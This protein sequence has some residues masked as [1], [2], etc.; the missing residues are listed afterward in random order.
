MKKTVLILCL[1]LVSCGL[2]AQDRSIN[3]ETSDFQTALAKAKQA[4]R[5]LFIDCYTSWCGPCKMLAK[6]VFTNNA[7]AD[8]FNANFVSMKV[9]CE[10]GEGPQIAGQFGV[11]SYPTLLF[12]DGDGNLVYKTTGASAPDRFLERVKEG[13]NPENLLSVKEKKYAEGVRDRALM[14][15]LIA[16]YKDRRDNKKAV[17][18]S[19]ELL[20]ALN[21]KELLN[22]EMWDV[23]QYYFVSGYGSKWWN[24]IIEHSDE[25]VGI[26]G[27]EAVANKIGETLHPYLFGFACG[28]DRAK[29]KADFEN[30]KT[31]VDRFQPKQKETLYAFIELGKSASSDNFNGYFKTVMRV[32]PKMDAGEHYRFWFN[33][34][35]NLEPNLSAKQ[36]KQLVQL[37]KSDMEK[38]NEYMQKAYKELL[39]KM[40]E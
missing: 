3:F 35:N 40:G 7:V 15:D 29:N 34:W 33:A 28:H 23:I 22:K 16:T 17:A 13:L 18:L 27:K 20:S 6:D 8:Y 4:N 38:S 36:K 24:F 10:K 2:F 26:V 21:E 37:V 25:Y 39:G 30:N 12:I 14:L 5:L 11:S 31:L 1:W 32:V 19:K 9:D